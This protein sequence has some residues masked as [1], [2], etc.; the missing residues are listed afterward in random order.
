MKEFRS[1]ASNGQQIHSQ[2]AK[3]AAERKA[4]AK[5]ERAASKEAA[6]ARKAE[7]AAAKALKQQVAPQL[8]APRGHSVRQ[9]IDLC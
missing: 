1:T 3:A 7:R 6:A 5:A 8:F 9:I 4:A 2:E